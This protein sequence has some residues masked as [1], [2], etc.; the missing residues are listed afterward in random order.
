[1]CQ[2]TIYGQ[3]NSEVPDAIDIVTYKFYVGGE[4][5][6]CK[7]RIEET[8]LKMEGVK[9]AT[10]DLKLQSLEVDVEESFNIMAMHRALAAAGHDTNSIKADD[11]VYNCLLY[12]SP[13]P[14]D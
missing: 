14:R 7:D 11:E 8:A 2:G 12:T 1:M 13:S 9:S 6:M 3:Q 10:Y 5:D 4:C